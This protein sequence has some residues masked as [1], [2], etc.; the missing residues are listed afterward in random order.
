M[1]FFHQKICPFVSIYTSKNAYNKKEAHDAAERQ[2]NEGGT[3][4]SVLNHPDYQVLCLSDGHVLSDNHS[5]Q[6]LKVNPNSNRC[7]TIKRERH[8]DDGYS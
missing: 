3:P 5:Q 2:S 7:T 8:L 1:T 6:K 4:L